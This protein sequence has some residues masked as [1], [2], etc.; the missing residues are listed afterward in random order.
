M[1]SDVS[2]DVYGRVY[3][4]ICLP[5]H[6]VPYDMVFKNATI[7]GNIT[8]SNT[9]PVPTPLHSTTPHLIMNSTSI[10]IEVLV[11]LRY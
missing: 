10:V 1:Y 4:Y 5:Y 6:I 7:Y 3:Y 8:L 2:R 11:L 9:L